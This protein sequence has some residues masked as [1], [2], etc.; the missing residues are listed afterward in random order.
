[1]IYR[2]TKNVRAYRRYGKG[3]CWTGRTKRLAEER[4]AR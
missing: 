4:W 1:M 2:L 3:I